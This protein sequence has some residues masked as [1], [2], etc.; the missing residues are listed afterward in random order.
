[1]A[2]DVARAA[3]VFSHERQD[4]GCWQSSWQVKPHGGARLGEGEASPPCKADNSNK[5]KNKGLLPAKATN[6]YR[7]A[8]TNTGVELPVAGRA[9]AKNNPRAKSI[10]F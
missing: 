10:E 1:V 6:P 9:R 4:A 3:L 2:L 8:R 7:L 5:K